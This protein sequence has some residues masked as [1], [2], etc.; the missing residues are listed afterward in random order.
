MNTIWTQTCTMEILIYLLEKKQAI[1]SDFIYGMRQSIINANT[2]YNAIEILTDAKLIKEEIGNNNS[3]L[4]TITSLGM[5][6]G[7]LAKEQKIILEKNK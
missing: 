3:R 1:I 7:E 6:I 5:Q 4:F 2:I